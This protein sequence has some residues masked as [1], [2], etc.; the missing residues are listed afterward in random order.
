VKNKLLLC[1]IIVAVSVTVL[2]GIYIL[3]TKLITRTYSVTA[4]GLDMPKFDHEI[5]EWLE[6]QPGVVHDS[7]E[8]S[9]NWNNNL[10]VRLQMSQ[11]WFGKPE[12]PNVYAKCSELGYRFKTDRFFDDPDFK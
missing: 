8:V 6:A 7:V 2:L 4:V 5:E 12:F 3:A 1:S 10:H 11:T 9:R